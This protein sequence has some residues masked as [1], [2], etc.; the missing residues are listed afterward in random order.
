MPVADDAVAAVSMIWAAP[1]HDGMMLHLTHDLVADCGSLL[2]A[3]ADL[4]CLTSL[5]IAVRNSAILLAL[6][7][8]ALL[9]AASAVLVPRHMMLE[10]VKAC[11][12]T[13]DNQWPVGMVQCM[14][15]CKASSYSVSSYGVTAVDS[16]DLD[17]KAHA[18]CKEE[19]D[20]VRD[21]C[22]AAC[23]SVSKPAET[24]AVTGS[25]DTCSYCRC[26]H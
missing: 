20:P 26:T 14:A 2:W 12:Q 24:P 21:R 9:S 5:L 18:A 1:C 11:E 19:Q 23:K 8:V 3:S 13:W 17:G 15:K 6:L 10:D 4:Y 25:A 7:L 22:K 16:A